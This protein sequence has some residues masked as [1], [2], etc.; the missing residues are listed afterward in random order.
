MPGR[1]W[2]RFLMAGG[3]KRLGD[4][5]ALAHGQFPGKKFFALAD[6]SGQKTLLQFGFGERIEKST[7]DGTSM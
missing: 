7:K 6:S 4:R 2:K 3:R 1:L 5:N